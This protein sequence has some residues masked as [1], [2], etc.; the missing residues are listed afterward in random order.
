MVESLS[1]DRDITRRQVCPLRWLKF[2]HH[3]DATPCV[4]PI[5][6][7]MCAWLLDVPVAICTAHVE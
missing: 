5:P 1:L 3:S 6:K 2:N 4:L 7:Y